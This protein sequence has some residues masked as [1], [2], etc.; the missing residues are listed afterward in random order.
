MGKNEE[1]TYRKQI[2]ELYAKTRSKS[3]KLH[4]EARLYLPGGDTRTVT[5]FEPF[6]HY[7]ERGEGAYLYDA[8]GNKLLDFQNNYTSLIHGHAH[9]RR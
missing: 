7:I 9:G 2:E 6:P 3:K 5:F 1:I 4:E 8:D